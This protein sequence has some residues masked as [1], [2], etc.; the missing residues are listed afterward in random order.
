MQN[1]FFQIPSIDLINL[2]PLIGNCK[3]YKVTLVYKS[4]VESNK[5]TCCELLS[6][7]V[8]ILAY[9]IGYNFYFTAILPCLDVEIEVVKLAINCYFASVNTIGQYQCTNVFNMFGKDKVR[10]IW[11]VSYKDV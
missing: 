7:F 6:V 1:I 2:H 3:N 5:V 8:I 9:P 11:E 10:K 4:S